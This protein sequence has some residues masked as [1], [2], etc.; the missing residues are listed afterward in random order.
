MINTLFHENKAFCTDIHST[1]DNTS[2]HSIICTRL[3]DAKRVQALFVP[4]RIIFHTLPMVFINAL[5]CLLPT[6]EGGQNDTSPPLPTS[7]ITKSYGHMRQSHPTRP[8]F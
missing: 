3:G 4:Q 5:L 6:I 8:I 1:C 2:P 7:N